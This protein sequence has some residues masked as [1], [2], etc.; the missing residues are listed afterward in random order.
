[1]RTALASSGAE[2]LD[3]TLEAQGLRIIRT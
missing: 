1:V 3:F 2:V